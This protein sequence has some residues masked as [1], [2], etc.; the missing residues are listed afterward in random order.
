MTRNKKV[1]LALMAVAAMALPGCAAGGA[2]GDGAKSVL[3]L[4]RS[5]PDKSLKT[6]VEKS[7]DIKSVNFSVTGKESGSASNLSG[8]AQ[9]G[10]KAAAEVKTTENGKPMT[11]LMHGSVLHAT[12][13]DE[14]K[15]GPLAGKKWLKMDLTKLTKEQAD[16]LGGDAPKHFQAMLDQL[17]PKFRLQQIIDAG[18]LKV[19]GEETVDGVK[20]VHYT[21]T[22]TVDRFI[23][24][25]EAGERAE[26]EKDVTLDAWVDEKYQLRKA[27]VLAGSVDDWTAVYTKH[28][29]PVTITVP[30][31]AEVVDFA[32]LMAMIKTAQG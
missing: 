13:P 14:Q 18:D 11:I 16:E 31:A 10:D 19:A 5:D 2:A 32:E 20:T 22:I 12:V 26:A 21:S 27:K 8:S 3:E 29:E 23:A 24:A 6:A 1:V 15:E 9:F 25:H 30:P 28:N 4:L 17:N 7:G